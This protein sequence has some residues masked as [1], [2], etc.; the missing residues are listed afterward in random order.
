MTQ[1]NKRRRCQAVVY[2]RDTY[3]STGRGPHGF[4]LCYSREQCER[5]SIGDTDWCWQHDK[6]KNWITKAGYH[7]FIDD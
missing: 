4:E 6:Q 2:K 5:A 1:K 3:R 7:E